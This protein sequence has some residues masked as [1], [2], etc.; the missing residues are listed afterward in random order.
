MTVKLYFRITVMLL[1]QL[2]QITG[3]LDIWNYQKDTF[4][5]K[6][7]ES[8]QIGPIFRYAVENAKRLIDSGKVV[9]SL[10][11]IRTVPIFFPQVPLV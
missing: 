8:G 3:I 6:L 5:L 2:V 10:L 1:L 9:S 7:Q 4:L 11:K